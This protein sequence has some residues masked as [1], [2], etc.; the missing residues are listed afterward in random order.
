MSSAY[1]TTLTLSDEN[2][3]LDRLIT[4]DALGVITKIICFYPDKSVRN[5]AEMRGDVQHGEFIS[6][7][8]NGEIEQHGF[9]I[10]GKKNGRFISN[11]PSGRLWIEQHYLNGKLHG[12]ISY[13]DEQTGNRTL[14]MNL[15]HD[16]LHGLYETYDMN[17]RVTSSVT[18]NI[19]ALE[20]VPNGYDQKTGLARLSFFRRYASP[21]ART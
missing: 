5:T 7:H 14:R 20:S 1:E 11:Y 6:F 12:E 2:G 13:Y 19:G 8:P 18:Y 17:G 9:F 3:F 15:R 10:N 16:V 4:R 21:W